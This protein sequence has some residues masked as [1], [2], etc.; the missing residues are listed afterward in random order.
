MFGELLLRKCGLFPGGTETQQLELIYML[1]G[2]P[3][4]ETAEILSKLDGWSKMQFEKTYPNTMARKFGN[5]DDTAVDLLQRILNMN[6]EKRFTAEQCMD[7][8]YF[9]KGEGTLPWQSLPRFKVEGG[10]EWE[11]KKRMEEGKRQRQNEVKR[12][13][14]TAS[15]RGSIRLN[16]T[17]VGGRG[18]GEGGTLV[19]PKY[20]ITKGGSVG[21][22]LVAAAAAPAATVAKPTNP[23][24]STPPPGTGSTA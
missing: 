24:K 19:K 17:K 16:P 7:H 4:G 12:P 1:C 2:T 20:K 5:V 9:W 21:K 22:S 8:L 23:S 14:W 15:G 3:T 6:P 11:A 18:K 13:S 10:H